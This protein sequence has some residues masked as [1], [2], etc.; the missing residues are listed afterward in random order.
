MHATSCRLW[1]LTCLL[2]L[3][4]AIGEFGVSVGELSESNLNRQLSLALGSLSTVEKRAQDL[5]H[6]QAQEDTITFMATG[7]KSLVANSRSET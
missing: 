3:A 1:L 4:V 7:E 2:D 6:T 5:Q